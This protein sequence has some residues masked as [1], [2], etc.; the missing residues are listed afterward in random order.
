MLY[1]RKYF[2]IPLRVND[3]W[4]FLDFNE[5]FGWNILPNY[6]EN[7]NNNWIILIETGIR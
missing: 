3:N 4:I 1:Y 6:L 5:H 2:Q 7:C